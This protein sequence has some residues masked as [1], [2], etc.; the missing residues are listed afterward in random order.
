[1]SY[2][3][4]P[5]YDDI[6]GFVERVEDVLLSE[7]SWST[8]DSDC[9]GCLHLS[10]ESVNTEDVFVGPPLAPPDGVSEQT[11]LVTHATVA[12][13]K[14]SASSSRISVAGLTWKKLSGGGC[15][16]SS[17]SV[18]S[19]TPIKP[20]VLPQKPLHLGRM[21]RQRDL[22]AAGAQPWNKN[23]CAT[24]NRRFAY[25][26]TL[27]IYVYEEAAGG[28]QLC[29]VLAE[30]RKTITSLAWHP[31]LEDLMASSSE[32][33]TV[34]VWS[35]KQQVVLH[36]ISLC[37]CPI[38]VAW[39]P[40]SA[41]RE[42]V[43]FS[44]AR[45]PV[46]LWQHQDSAQPVPYGETHAYRGGVALFR[47]H[48]S[49][50]GRL[51]VAHTDA[52]ISLYGDGESGNKSNWFPG[53]DLASDCFESSAG[54]ILGLEWALCSPD[55]LLL[56]YSGGQLWLVDTV[57]FMVVTEFSVPSS[58]VLASVAWLPQAPGVFVSGDRDKGILRVWTASKRTPMCSYSLKNMGF[59]ELCGACSSATSDDYQVSRS[60]AVVP[61]V[62]VLCLF[63]DGGVGLY[64]V[65]RK[66]WIFNREHGHT[67]TIF[68]CS[69]KPDNCD[70]LATGSFDGSI[71]VWRVD[72]LE[73]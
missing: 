40:L 44:T 46:Q 67:E 39:R 5:D 8:S 24:K 9:S 15:R 17:D 61:A 62:S 37:R 63:K 50:S 48:P 57:A 73:A 23:I 35:V 31:R 55:F 13:D 7:S 10:K 6:H 42:V 21:L 4:R 66:H 1:M 14:K 69:F 59:H 64:Q 2:L 38:L 54:S 56:C 72:S 12:R 49:I 60:D 52:R 51:A 70:L 47:W 71:K 33:Q 68:D 28:W 20:R 36:A 16:K 45:G 29:S 3:K 26:A 41:T 22:L 18:S 19:N 58:V 34:C 27:V 53:N 43:T 32:D 25:A 30:H 11:P 65:R